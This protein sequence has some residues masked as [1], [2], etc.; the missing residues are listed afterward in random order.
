MPQQRYPG[1][2][3]FGAFNDPSL[4]P[5][6]MFG[7][8]GFGTSGAFGGDFFG[9][10]NDPRYWP[11]ELR[12]A[13]GFGSG[14]APVDTFDPYGLMAAL[15]GSP[16][17]IDASALLPFLRN[18]TPPPASL[19][20]MPDF[21]GLIP[22]PA[23]STPLSGGAPAINGVVGG[24]GY[25]SFDQRYARSP[26]PVLGSQPPIDASALLPFLQNESLPTV[27]AAN[28]G[29]APPGAAADGGLPAAASDTSDQMAQIPPVYMP[30][31][32]TADGA[33]NAALASARHPEPATARPALC[34][35]LQQARGPQTSRR[36]TKVS[37]TGGA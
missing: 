3:F 5:S 25:G 15:G 14:G 31:P 7:P 26:T 16:P 36:G 9:A 19:P 12:G 29:R 32:R 33:R 30:P 17:R 23:P 34:S 4:R 22:T 21:V 37:R 28:G 35:E 1:T 24:S 10:F 27:G 13:A 2:E 11:P 20:A 18:P 6:E 8:R